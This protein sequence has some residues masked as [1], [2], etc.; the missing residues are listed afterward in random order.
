MA[1]ENF[2]FIFGCTCLSLGVLSLVLPRVNRS[3]RDGLERADQDLAQE[4][5][6][7]GASESFLIGG[8]IIFVI[9]LAFVAA[10]FLR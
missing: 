6:P 10:A 8:A 5:W 2:E 9:G 4:G 3:L 1:W 7:V